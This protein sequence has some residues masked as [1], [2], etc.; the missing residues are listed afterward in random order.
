[1]TNDYRAACN[2]SEFSF[3]SA[4][5]GLDEEPVIHADERRVAAY[6]PDF[7]IDEGYWGDD[8]EE[9][10]FAA[11][12]QGNAKTLGAFGEELACEL[13]KRKDYIV[14]ERNWACP[15]GEADI[16]AIDEG[17]LVFV[18]V[19]TRAGSDRGFPQEAVTAKKRSRY[20]RIAYYFLSNYDGDDMRVRFDVIAIQVMPNGKGFV[21]HIVNAFGQGA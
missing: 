18:E 11:D 9:T 10:C 6:E 2:A 16:I 7:A 1:M 3:G 20:E 12:W 19:K 8:E 17:C 15:A 4:P 21:K 5:F 14:V 13:L